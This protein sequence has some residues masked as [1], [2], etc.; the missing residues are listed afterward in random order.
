MSVFEDSAKKLSEFGLTPYEAKVYLAAV[1]LGLTSASRI[2]KHANIRREEVYRT[3]PKLEKAGL[4]DRVLGR[5]VKIRAMPLKDA[6]AILIGRKEEQAKKEISNLYSKRDVILE[7][8]ET[9]FGAVEREEEEFHFTLISE[10][11]AVATRIATLIESAR[12]SI[13]IVD[14]SNE[15]IRFILNYEDALNGTKDRGVKVRMLTVCPDD[16]TVI[17]RAL[18]KHVPANS[19]SLRYAETLPSRYI[20]FDQKQAIITTTP[21][22][23][24]SDKKCLWTDDRSLVGLIERD[25]EELFARSDD[26]ESFRLSPSEKITRIMKHLQPRDHV[27]LVYDSAEAK[28]ST[29]F[30]YL[31]YGLDNGEAGKYVCSEESPNEI[32]NAM[33]SFGIEVSKYEEAGALDILSYTDIYIR[34]GKFSIDSIMDTWNGYYTKALSDGFKG[35]RVTGEMDCFMQHSLVDELIEYEKA[36]HT[37]L[38]I[39]LTALCAYNADTLANVENPIDV[40]SEIVKAHGKVL[41]ASKDNTV[42]KIEIRKA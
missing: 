27:V 8:I 26:W 1:R 6:L 38:D 19:F 5:P 18:E 40:Y 33:K 41:F 30:N 21:E 31:K 22:E 16:E 35:L 34:N 25:F 15:V 24:L 2:S 20:L 3:L 7:R 32:R 42:G 11:D 37:I 17:P 13:D 14:S 23:T 36:L 9:D 10:K 12:N 39:P 4:I 29:L 28:R